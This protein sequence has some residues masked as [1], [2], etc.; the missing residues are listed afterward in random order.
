M[1]FWYSEQSPRSVQYSKHSI[2]GTLH[3][4]SMFCRMTPCSFRLHWHQN[5]AEAAVSDNQNNH[6]PRHAKASDVLPSFLALDI[7]VQTITG[8][9]FY[10]LTRLRHS[11]HP[12][13]V[14]LS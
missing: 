9:N 3:I 1:L 13:G 7:R 12:P 2:D 11:C 4:W 14:T 8:F 6:D 10:N 5:R